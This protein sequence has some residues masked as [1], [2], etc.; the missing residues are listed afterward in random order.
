VLIKLVGWFSRQWWLW[1]GD[2]A[3]AVGHVCY[4]VIFLRPFGDRV[5]LMTLF[6]ALV[7]R[8]QDLTRM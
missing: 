4:S 5:T 1:I 3:A 7:T 8:W 6:Y 2:I